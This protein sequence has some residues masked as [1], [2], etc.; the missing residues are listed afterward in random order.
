MSLNNAKNIR[1]QKRFQFLFG[2]YGV[3]WS[4]NVQSVDTLVF[5][6]DFEWLRVCYVYDTSGR[7][8]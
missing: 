2:W 8:D 7:K 4:K 5:I 6:E 3:K 1:K